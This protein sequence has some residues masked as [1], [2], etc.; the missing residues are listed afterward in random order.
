M[1]IIHVVEKFFN[2]GALSSLNQI[3]K[4][5]QKSSFIKNQEVIC[6]KFNSNKKEKKISSYFPNNS[7]VFETQ[8]FINYLKSHG[9]NEA[10]CIFH[11][12]MC[13]PTKVVSSLINQGDL[14]SIVVNHTYSKSINFN[15]LYKF[16]ACVAVSDHMKSCIEKINPKMKVF[17]IKNIVDFNGISKFLGFQTDNNLY[18]TGRINALNVIKYN[19]EFIKWISSLKFDKPHLHQ[20]MG[21]GQFMNDATSL[22]ANLRNSYSNTQMLGSILDEEKK[23]GIL[24]SWDLFLYEINRPEGTSMSVL[25]SLACGVPV[26]CSNHPGN[27]EIIIDGI[28]GFVFDDLNQANLILKNLFSDKQSL[29][30]LKKSTLEWAKNHLSNEIL[31]KKYEEVIKWVAENHRFRKT[32]SKENQVLE[33]QKNEKTEVI[34]NRFQVKYNGKVVK[35]N[36]SLDFNIAKNKTGTVVHAKSNNVILS[37]VI[38][39]TKVYI[40]VFH[41][42]ELVKVEKVYSDFFALTNCEV[43]K[44]AL[45]DKEIG[46]CFIVFDTNN[47]QFKNIDLIDNMRLKNSEILVSSSSEICSIK[48]LL[49]YNQ[50][51]EEKEK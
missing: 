12:L 42:D 50:L 38:E 23:F 18:V 46:F 3:Y 27:N 7:K 48:N 34:K 31:A 25:E 21:T 37:D 35:R 8:Q 45:E 20:Y 39:Y 16:D 30:L 41:P 32:K 22:A 36:K 2:S 26:I 4:S 51:W 17:T 14:P 9:S 1:K 33:V 10:V 5:L 24:K 11:K 19:D 49:R 47:N 40:P 6:L 13:S 29:D 15:K 43:K 44:L 28:N